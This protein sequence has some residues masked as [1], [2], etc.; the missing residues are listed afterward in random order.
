MATTCS[1]YDLLRIKGANWS[2]VRRIQC[3]NWSCVRRNLCLC[4]LQF[5]TCHLSELATCQ[6]VSQ[7]GCKDRISDQGLNYSVYLIAVVFTTSIYLGFIRE[8][9]WAD[10]WL[11][12]IQPGPSAGE[13][14]FFFSFCDIKVKNRLGGAPPAE[15]IATWD[16]V[17]LLPEGDLVP[18][19]KLVDVLQSQ[20]SLLILV[21]RGV[22]ESEWSSQSRW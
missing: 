8:A 11:K 20:W 18:N 3:A 15:T 12:S 22:F 5:Y 17:S 9:S 21:H 2:R 6:S 4:V 10:W 1:N 7:W 19:V 14:Q 13:E 16:D